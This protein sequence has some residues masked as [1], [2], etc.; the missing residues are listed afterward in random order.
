MNKFERRIILSDANKQMRNRS[1][2]ND[3]L[4][5]NFNNILKKNVNNTT[6]VITSINDDISTLNVII[7]NTVIVHNT[8]INVY[9]NNSHNTRHRINPESI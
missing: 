5:T 4:T 9:D 3:N 1:F 8:M 6:N 2:F 7:N